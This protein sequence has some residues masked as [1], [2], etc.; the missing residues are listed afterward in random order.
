MGQPGTYGWS[1]RE[2]TG[3]ISTPMSWDAASKIWTGS[4]GNLY[5]AADW[6]H[7]AVSA[8]AERRW[9]APHGGTVTLTGVAKNS[10]S[11]GGNGIVASIWKNGTKIWGDQSVTTLAGVTHDLT[12]TASAG[13][14]ISFIVDAAAIPRTTRRPGFPPSTSSDPACG[15]QLP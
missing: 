11:T 8:H 1:Y 2:R 9:R 3:G 6:V 13:D 10:D 15:V 12:T 7:P 5:I 14:V 4:V